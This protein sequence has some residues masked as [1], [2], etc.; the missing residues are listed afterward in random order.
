MHKTNQ[1]IKAGPPKN[2]KG[3]NSGPP[4]LRIDNVINHRQGTSADDELDAAGYTPSLGNDDSKQFPPFSPTPDGTRR[5]MEADLE[6]G[7]EPRPV[8]H[9]TI[10][11]QQD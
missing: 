7:D 1:N 10:T 3:L 8:R 11:I 9:R 5:E 2:G 6:D 4:R